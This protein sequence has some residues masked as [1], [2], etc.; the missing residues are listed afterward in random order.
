MS[1][2]CGVYYDVLKGKLNATVATAICKLRAKG[3]LANLLC[4]NGVINRFVELIQGMDIELV[5][6]A[7]HK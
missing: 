2:P 7:A 3:N 5:D 1:G 6:D 4:N